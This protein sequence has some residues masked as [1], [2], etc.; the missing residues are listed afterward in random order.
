MPVRIGINGFG[1]IGRSYLRATLGCDADVDVVAINDIADAATLASLLEWDS[2]AGHL[3]G[4][5]ADGDA[6]LVAGAR[7][8]ITSEREPARIVFPLTLAVFIT[9]VPPLDLGASTPADAGLAYESVSLRTDGGVRLDGW[10]MPS[11]NGAAVVLLGGASSTRDKE[12]G[13]AAVFVHRGYGV[14]FVD[15]RGHGGSGGDPCCGAGS[16]TPTLARRWTH[17]HS[18]PDV[19]DGRVGAVGISMDGE[20]TFQWESGGSHTMRRSPGYS[21]R[22]S[23]R[24]SR[25]WRTPPVNVDRTISSC[26]RSPRVIAV[27]DF[28]KANGAP[29][30]ADTTA[31]PTSAR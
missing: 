20:L 3:D 15:V 24:R 8:R 23:R 21:R 26:C 11:R 19:R 10:N 31:R 17:L 27:I 4:V 22:C 18:R 28:A 7:I 6:L 29:S 25:A 16:V 2:L 12:I 1:R 5:Q 30:S 13:H 14:L 9:N